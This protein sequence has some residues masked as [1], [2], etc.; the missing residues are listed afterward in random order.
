MV[1]FRIV[2]RSGVGLGSGREVVWF[3]DFVTVLQRIIA[4]F[5]FRSRLKRYRKFSSVI[6]SLERRWLVLQGY[7]FYEFF[8]GLYLSK[9]QKRWFLVI[10]MFL[11]QVIV[12]C[13]IGKVFVGRG[14]YEVQVFVR[15]LQYFMLYR[16]LFSMVQRSL[17]RVISLSWVR[18]CCM[19]CIWFQ[20]LV[21]GLQQKILLEQIVLVSEL[22]MFFVRNRQLCMVQR[23]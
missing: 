22:R 7:S 23:V 9:R 20:M 13:V 4:V 15:G 8:I 3:Q 6:M 5:I 1:L 14:A 2:Q 12:S 10:Q 19:G 11:R 18:V 17:F 21:R 16:Y